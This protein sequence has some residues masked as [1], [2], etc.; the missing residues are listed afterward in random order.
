MAQREE[1]VLTCSRTWWGLRE[2]DRPRWKQQRTTC[3]VALPSF[4]QVVYRHAEVIEGEEVVTLRPEEQGTQTL[5]V[6]ASK[7]P[8]GN[9]GTAHDGGG[10]VVLCQALFQST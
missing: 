5:F 8:M 6:K 3:N 7:N 4:D 2:S 10:L 9:M 1:T